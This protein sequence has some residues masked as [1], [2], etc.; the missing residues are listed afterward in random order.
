MQTRVVEKA[1]HAPNLASTLNIGAFNIGNVGGAWLGGAVLTH[2][3]GLDALPWAAAVVAV[4]ALAVTWFAARLD[5]P[6][7]PADA[8]VAEA[9]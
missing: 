5:T 2:G 4:A 7:V 9:C 8:K 1:R 6:R 3:Y